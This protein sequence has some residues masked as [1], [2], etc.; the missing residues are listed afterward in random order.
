MTPIAR[1]LARE[2]RQALP[3]TCFFLVVFHVAAFNRALMEET[4]GITPE[5]SAVATIMA[6]IMGKVILVVNKLRFVNR[7][8]GQPLV[9]PILWKAVIF[10]TLG[11]MFQMLEEGVPLAYRLHS[12]SAGVGQLLDEM[13]WPKFLANHLL[14]LVWLFI[15]CVAVELIREFGAR[16]M[17]QLFF[18]PR[19]S[20]THRTGKRSGN[21]A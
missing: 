18:G 14:L 5:N 6:L 19:D 8:S 10:G 13:V 12:V 11:S 16:E 3:P 9:L 7:F 21:H 17:R 4:Y 2:L 20:R 1:F 15:Y